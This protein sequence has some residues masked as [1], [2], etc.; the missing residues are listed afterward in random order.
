MP[1]DRPHVQ[2]L[3]E[4]VR[5]FMETEVQPALEGSLSFHTRVA[6]NVLKIVERELVQGQAL[7]DGA[8]ERLQGLLGREGELDE[9]SEALIE[10]IR[11]G[12]LDLQT[13]GLAEHL[14]ATVLGKLAIDN[15]RYK[16]YQ[17]AIAGEAAGQA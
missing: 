15:P 3:V 2:E 16:S 5:E 7:Q 11:A 9:L 4:A 13:P 17:R 8:R 6:V 12:E 10:G 1:T 14:R